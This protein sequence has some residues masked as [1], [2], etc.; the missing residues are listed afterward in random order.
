MCIG[1]LH[2]NIEYI[3]KYIS[4][5]TEYTLLILTDNLTHCM[6]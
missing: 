3:L 2:I 6:C 5:Y 1:R 4:L